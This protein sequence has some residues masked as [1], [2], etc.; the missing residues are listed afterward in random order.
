[1]S[2]VLKSTLN[3][4]AFKGYIM[5]IVIGKILS[6]GESELY[7]RPL[8]EFFDEYFQVVYQET[9]MDEET[10]VAKIND[11]FQKIQTDDSYTYVAIAN[12]LDFMQISS[13]ANIISQ[14]KVYGLSELSYGSDHDVLVKLEKL[15]RIFKLFD[16]EVNDEVI[17]L[18]LNQ[19]EDLLTAT[20]YGIG[21][22]QMLVQGVS[23]ITLYTLE[24]FTIE[25]E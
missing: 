17:L 12:K 14:F 23:P 4:Y 18:Q 22:K 20:S 6:G 9:I 25:Q 1:M 8:I 3:G 16:L 15:S 21:Y 7:V 11:L 2:K 24:D 13:F 19:I 10:V 5:D